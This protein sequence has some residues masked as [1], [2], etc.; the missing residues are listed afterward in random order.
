[1]CEGSCPPSHGLSFF[2]LRLNRQVSES[3]DILKHYNFIVLDLRH[4]LEDVKDLT[5]M[6]L[7]AVALTS[8][9]K[10]DAAGCHTVTRISWAVPD[11]CIYQHIP[12]EQHS[13]LCCHRLFRLNK[14]IKVHKRPTTGSFRVTYR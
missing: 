14:Q 9:H 11:K 13:F 7:H 1:M 12:L 3:R 6:F 5:A 4:R 8:I 2:I 10:T